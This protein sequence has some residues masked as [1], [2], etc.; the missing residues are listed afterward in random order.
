[1]SALNPRRQFLRPRP[2]LSN[3]NS[4]GNGHSN[5]SSGSGIVTASSPNLTTAYS[6]RASPAAPPSSTAPGGLRVAGLSAVAAARKSS[7]NALTQGSLASVPDASETYGLST[8]LDEDSLSPTSREGEGEGRMPAYMPPRGDEADVDVG[9]L[10]GVPG[11]MHGLV[12]FVG[13]VA[14]KN[15]VFAGVE[16]SEEFAAKGKNNGDVDG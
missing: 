3:L 15:G 9:D 4:N 11:N 13:T 6:G 8:V 1:M 2:S 10:V 7:F 12:K 14:G 16:L 5:G